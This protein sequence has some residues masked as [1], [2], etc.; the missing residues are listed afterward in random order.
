MS[1]REG[2]G[3]GSVPRRRRHHRGHDR[4]A[5]NQNSPQANGLRVRIPGRSC[6]GLATSV[7]VGWT[8]TAC[9]TTSPTSVGGSHGRASTSRPCREDLLHRD[10]GS[11]TSRG[12]SKIDGYVPSARRC[13]D[14]GWADRLVAAPISMGFASAVAPELSLVEDLD[15]GR[16]IELNNDCLA[17]AYGNDRMD[18]VAHLSLRTL[19][20]G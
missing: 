20:N 7:D 10:R 14:N 17:R 11:D 19:L 13:R 15:V 18:E 12:A 6:G 9:L 2:S 16:V 8:R 5:S 3:I 4:V 1:C